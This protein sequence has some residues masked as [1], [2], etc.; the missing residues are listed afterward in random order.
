MLCRVSFHLTNGVI[1]LDVDVMA[2]LPDCVI[3]IGNQIGFDHRHKTLHG[4]IEAVKWWESATAIEV[5][6]QREETGD[7]LDAR[8]KQLLQDEDVVFVEL[9]NGEESIWSETRG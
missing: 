6:I 1:C 5:D 8:A 3:A 2:E 4:V 9:S 7:D